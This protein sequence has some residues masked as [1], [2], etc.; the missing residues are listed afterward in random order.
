L[1]GQPGTRRVGAFTVVPGLIWQFGVDPAP[2]LAEAGVNSGILAQPTGRIDWEGLARLLTL[3]AERTA[4]PHFGLLA[5]RE[6]RLSD[7]GLLGELVRNSPTVDAA[8]RE[9]VVNQHLNS[10][11]AL[12]FLL[13]QG[14]AVDLGYAIYVPFAESTRHIYDAVLAAIANIM[15]ELCGDRW[16]AFEVL[17]PHSSPLDVAPYLQ[18]FKAP[19]RFDSAF[20]AVR[21]SL[22]W[23][24]QPVR[25]ADPDRL[26]AAQTRASD[27][28]KSVLVDKTFRA[29]RTLLLQGKASGDDVAQ[30]LAIHRRTLNRRLNAEGATF[31]QVLD[32]VRF[33]VAKEL[34]ENSEVSLAEI[35]HALGYAHDS[36]LLS[37]FRRWTGT[38]PGAW[39]LSSR[40]PRDP[41]A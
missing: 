22:K 18:C 6:W 23:L 28:D 36:A 19:L 11:G 3:A 4:C 21:F 9:L 27:D 32:R 2:I 14:D 12:A 10:E 15:C 7:H 26:R 39:R 30:A 37:A 24:A 13:R 35:A 41:A 31:R 16:R 38:T 1:Q 5:G 8:L 34:L 25:G 33:A 17:F 40:I 20:C 29:L